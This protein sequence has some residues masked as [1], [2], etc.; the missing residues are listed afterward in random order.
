MY[1]KIHEYNFINYEN[2]QIIIYQYNDKYALADFDNSL[3]GRIV[4]CPIVLKTPYFETIDKLFEY[5][6]ICKI[7]TDFVSKTIVYK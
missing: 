6:K 7:Y 2:A 5:C 4:P 3:S 1:T